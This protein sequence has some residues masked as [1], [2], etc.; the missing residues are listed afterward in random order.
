MEMR[1]FAAFLMLLLCAPALASS[2]EAA[3]AITAV[4]LPVDSVTVYPDGLI[5]VK[6]TGALDTTIGEHKFVVNVPEAADIS[7]VLLNASNAALERVIYD[8]NPAYTLN[9]SSAGPQRFALSYLLYDAGDWSAKYDLHLKNDSMLVNA[10]AV[11]SNRGGEDLNNVRLKLVTGLPPAVEPYMPGAAPQTSKRYESAML[12]EDMAAAEPS[13]QASG[14]KET[15]HIF[16]LKGR[17]DLL[18]DKEIGFPLFEE[19]VP[20]VR[21]YAWNADILEEGPAT[22]KILVNNTMQNPWPSGK[23]MLYSD[24][25]YVSTIS[26]PYTPSGT[27]ASI[28]IGPSADI[29]V[30]KKLSSYNI[31]KNITEIAASDKN[32]TVEETTESWAYHLKIESNLDRPAILEVTDTHPKEARIVASTQTPVETTATRLKWKLAL[33]P[34]E[35]TA[36][37]YAYQI[38]T[39]RSLD[40]TD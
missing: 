6:R 26:M 18:K 22:E 40:N 14:E 17:K 11:V 2:P 30:D 13:I 33:K 31:T 5:A 37:D 19:T 23:A 25:D 39:T 15:L 3:E 21:I 28:V 12:S 9:F 1:L 27:N 38:V 35:K 36:I 8:A 34:R 7:S 32:H 29:K 20:L 10:E 16:E 24:D 4:T